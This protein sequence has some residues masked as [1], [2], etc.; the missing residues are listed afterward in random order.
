MTKSLS[1]KKRVE[2]YMIHRRRLGYVDA[3]VKSSLLKFANFADKKVHAGPITIDL[4]IEWATASEKNTRSAWARRLGLV[5]RLAKYYKVIE[6]ETEIPPLNLYGS[7]YRRPTPYIYSQNEIS[8]LLT[9]TC[10]LEPID[11]LKPI[12]FKYLLGLLS[13]TGLRI[14]EAIKLKNND[15]DLVKGV[16]TIH[17]TKAHKSRYVP[18]HAT[19][20]NAL[21]KYVSIRNKRM[22]SVTNPSFFLIDKGKSLNIVQTD[23]DYRFVRQK[24]G[25]TKNQRLYDFRH[26]FTCHRL[27]KWYEE[28]K[29][30]DAM[31]V[32]LS[33]YLGH[34]RVIDTYWY[35]T[36]TPELLS[37][38]SKRF[39]QFTN[40]SEGE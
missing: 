11:G 4:A 33:T 39:E 32:Y 19:T 13:S 1:M 5:H 40:Q 35:L 27:L 28:G 14:S 34:A 16:L 23:K 8:N 21:K 26:T 22:P 9:A 3:S 7:A 20:V 31:M 29:N 6:P 17:E 24:A 30:I 18:L 25:L 10:Q 12:T 2:T 36:A 38:V 37:V 15:V